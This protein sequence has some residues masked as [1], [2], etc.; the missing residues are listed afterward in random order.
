MF[1]PK[2]EK[3]KKLAKIFPNI[4][5]Q[6]E[7][8]FDKPTNVYIDFANVKHWQNKLEWRIDLKR[9]KQ[10]LDSFD[11]IHL[12]KFYYGILG[13]DKKE[14]KF[15]KI[16]KQCV[17]EAKTKPVKIMKISID[18]SSIDE[19]S[20]SVLKN[21][22]SKPLLHKLDSEAIE[23]LNGKLRGLNKRGVKF[24]EVLKCNFD[25]EM[26]RDMLVDYNNN[27]IENFI[28]WSGDSDFADP[29]EQ[30]IADGKKVAIFAI[31]R[32]IAVE[33]GKTKA[34]IFDIRKIKEFICWKKDLPKELE[35]L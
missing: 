3:I 34:Q 12:V 2:T 33:L 28:L 16:A 11:T 1:K 31:A 9:L 25:V 17:Y 4:V 29:I 22:I 27:H 35:G 14:N 8:T 19:N 24:L 21:F 10:F 30:L 26:G 7:K 20:S 13:D 5:K 32:R 18:V 23:F 6:L 15:I